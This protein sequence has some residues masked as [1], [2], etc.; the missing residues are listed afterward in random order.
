ME[1]HAQRPTKGKRRQTS[2]GQWA[3][4]D[5]PQGE[6]VKNQPQ[7]RIHGVHANDSPSGIDEAL[8]C[9]QRLVQHPLVTNAQPNSE[10]MRCQSHGRQPHV[11]RTR[12]HD[13]NAALRAWSFPS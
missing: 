12:S 7:V 2:G 6:L 11:P 3:K 1:G 10:Y 9:H 5:T 8:P 4:K 13:A